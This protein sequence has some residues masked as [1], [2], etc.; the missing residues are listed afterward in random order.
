MLSWI[1]PNSN[2]CSDFAELSWRS[3]LELFMFYYKNIFLSSQGN[4]MNCPLLKINR[5]R[6]WLQLYPSTVAATVWKDL[7]NKSPTY[8]QL[9]HSVKWFQKSWGTTQLPLHWAHLSGEMR[10]GSQG[11]L[12]NCWTFQPQV[13]LDFLCIQSPFIGLS[14]KNKQYACSHLSSNLTWIW[15]IE[16][17]LVTLT[18]GDKICLGVWEFEPGQSFSMSFSLEGL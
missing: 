7:K 9:S 14:S 15:A 1:R 6:Q 12:A 11:C 10:Q 18:T 17:Y 2:P 5:P 8:P 16:A 13:P 3:G 4:D